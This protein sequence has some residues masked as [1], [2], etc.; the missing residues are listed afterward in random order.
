MKE[1]TIGIPL[2]NS[3]PT[4]SFL[5]ILKML[6]NMGNK[7]NVIYTSNYPI[8]SARNEIVRRFLK[9]DS[10]YLL[11]IDSD[12]ILPENVL[13]RLMGLGDVVSGISF[14]KAYPYYPT[15]YKNAGEKFQPVVDY[16]KNKIIEVDAVGMF[17]TLV[18]REVF[19]NMERPWFEFGQTSDG[20]LIGED[21]MFC[22]KAKDLGFSIRSD[23]GLIVPHVGAIIDERA[24]QN[25]RLALNVIRKGK[26]AEV[27]K[28]I[29]GLTAE[30]IKRIT[31]I[32]EE[33]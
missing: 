9:R 22:R 12:Q 1:I 32:S 14:K 18:K 3:M 23:T 13:Q 15:I 8:E 4:Q 30:D 7:F 31:D 6:H 24:F 2:Y 21:L 11:F 33:F 5:S 25:T 29:D 28:F 26:Y 10:D 19:E 20:E 17:C 27:K 16:P